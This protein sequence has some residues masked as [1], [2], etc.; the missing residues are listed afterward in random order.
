MVSGTINGGLCLWRG[1]NCCK[2]V[3]DAHSG[4]VEALSAVN[5]R[6]GIVASGG[7]DPKVSTMYR[8]ISQ[9]G[10]TYDV[11]KFFFRNEIGLTGRTPLLS[12]KAE[13]LC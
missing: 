9:P 12:S 6:G 7:R 4:T 2:A 10:V 8:I 13:T 3:E 5:T 11:G 1:R